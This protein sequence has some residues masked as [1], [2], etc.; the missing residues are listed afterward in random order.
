MSTMELKD[1]KVAHERPDS[2]AAAYEKLCCLF[3]GWDD[4]M[5]NKTAQV[6]KTLSHP[7]VD[8]DPTIP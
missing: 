7:N 2:P 3:L 1:P 4:G 8:L 6:R 5:N